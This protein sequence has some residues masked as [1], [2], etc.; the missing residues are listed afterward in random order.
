MTGDYGNGSLTA[1]PSGPILIANS[2]LEAIGNSYVT[3]SAVSNADFTQTGCIRFRLTPLFTGAPADTQSLFSVVQDKDVTN[4]VNALWLAVESSS[5][6]RLYGFDS[7]NSLFLNA[8]LGNWSPTIGHEYIFELNYDFTTGATRLFIDGVQFGSTQT[9]TGSR[10]NVVAHMQI[11]KWI[12][13]SYSQ[14][15]RMREFEIF[16]TVQHTADHVPDYT[17]PVNIPPVVVPPVIAA[18]TL[19]DFL[20]DI[21]DFIGTTSLTNTEFNSLTIVTKEYSQAVYLAL[22]GVIDGRE[23]VSSIRNR[24]GSYFFAR[25]VAVLAPSSGKSNIFIGAEL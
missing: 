23:L 3:Y 13:S 2:R 9:G 1:F 5:A 22:L 10:T 7:A 16:N 8:S 15:F 20:N 25:G 4:T 18:Q 17:F 14:N 12:G 11:G 24:L 21:L 6:V 19:R